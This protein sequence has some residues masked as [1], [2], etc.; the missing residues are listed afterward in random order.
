MNFRNDISLVKLM[1]SIPE[2]VLKII[3]EFK[4]LLALPEGEL[5]YT[6]SISCLLPSWWLPLE[7]LAFTEQETT[8]L[9]QSFHFTDKKAEIQV[10]LLIQKYSC[11]NIWFSRTI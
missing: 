6:R 10:M 2:F 7:N 8:D 1:L 9:F 11:L 5:L 3:E 4:L